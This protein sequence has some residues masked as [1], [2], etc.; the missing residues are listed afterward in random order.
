MIGSIT[1]SIT[2]QEVYE[3]GV[4]RKAGLSVIS[5]A[6]TPKQRDRGGLAVSDAPS[7]R[8]IRKK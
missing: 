3:E 5:G 2:I 1:G 6:A 7:A 4:V 8:E